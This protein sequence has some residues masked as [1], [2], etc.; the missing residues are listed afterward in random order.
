MIEWGRA[1]CS[2]RAAPDTGIA[3]LRAALVLRP[4]EAH[5]LRRLGNLLLERYD[6]EEAS[7][8]FAKALEQAPGED[9][10]ALRLAHCLNALG[11]AREALQV[12]GG[13]LGAAA[14]YERA[15]ALIALDDVP[16]AEAM[17][18]RALQADPCH[19]RACVRLAG[20]LR[21]SGRH[22]ELLAMCEWLAARGVD[23]AQLMLDWGRALALAGDHARARALLFQR[24]RTP[25]LDDAVAP[26]VIALAAE[27]VRTNPHAISRFPSDEA[28]VGSSRVHALLNGARPEVMAA[29]LSTLQAAVDAHVA[30]LQPLGSFDP[31][32]AARPR[33]AMLRP[34]G[35]IQRNTD[36]ERWHTHRGGW[37]SGV[38][39]L[40][41]PAGVTAAGEAP[42][43]IEFGPP[44][45]LADA[46]RGRVPVWRHAPR[47]G[48]LL[49]APS[50]YHH[51]TIPS[52]ID[53]TRI[54]LAF[55]VVPLD[56]PA[57][58]SASIAA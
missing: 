9:D 2:D 8:C 45:S 26:D 57:E 42:G 53:D 41:I 16:G 50:H 33:R 15:L 48:Q 7:Q 58:T 18:R 43:C 27:D 25:V 30:S 14:D 51:R 32:L 54:C 55:D 17:L 39:Y 36:H 6:H 21:R 20:L 38:L 1:D 10:L 49:L 23:H 28:N 34:W 31:W 29:L 3:L 11:R 13:V 40:R 56:Q 37:M 22:V 19:R 24:K 4:G 5:L 44:P 12:L 47:A 46:L 52:G 35:L